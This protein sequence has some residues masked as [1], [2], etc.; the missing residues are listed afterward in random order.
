[1]IFHEALAEPVEPFGDG[2]LGE[3]GERPCAGIDLD[4]GNDA[5]A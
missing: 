2:L 5:M 4:A 1:V 3:A